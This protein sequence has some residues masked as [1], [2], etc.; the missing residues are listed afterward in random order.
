MEIENASFAADA[1]PES[2]FRLYA[3][4]PRS[5]F[6]T[7]ETSQRIVGYVIVRRDRW[8]AE[9]VSL[10]VHP[11][12]RHRGIGRLLMTAVVK[13]MKRRS[14]EVV[15]LMVHIKNTGAATFYRAQG[16]R[17]AGRVT[18]YYEDGGTGIRMRLKLAN[19]KA[20]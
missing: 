9:I 13:R 2:L 19:K 6:L 8:G 12:W 11:S 14:V 1:Y 17:A 7:A 10:A 15:R 20:S 5:L 4:D 3:A 16:F 18:E